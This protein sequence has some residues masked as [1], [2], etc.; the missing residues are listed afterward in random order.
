MKIVT[1][2][3][4]YLLKLGSCLI[5]LGLAQ[6]GNAQINRHDFVDPDAPNMIGVNPKKVRGFIDLDVPNMDGVKSTIY[7]NTHPVRSKR[8]SAVGRVTVTKRCGDCGGAVSSG[9]HA[10]QYCPHCGVHWGFES[11]SKD[12]RRLYAPRQKKAASTP[13]TQKTPPTVR[14]ASQ[15]VI[16]VPANA[17]APISSPAANSSA[18]PPWVM[19]AAVGMTGLFAG[20]GFTTLFVAIVL[21][22]SR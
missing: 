2:L 11:S 13:P 7:K 17:M 16:V 14:A 5:L 1:S 22:R 10:G 19:L 15:P 9:A 8:R 20:V 4:S 12:V 18:L 21:R 6:Y 3:S